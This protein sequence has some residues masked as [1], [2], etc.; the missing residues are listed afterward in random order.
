MPVCCFEVLCISPP[1]TL[2]SPALVIKQMI[3]MLVA[4]NERQFSGRLELFCL[5]AMTC[6][7]RK[8]RTIFNIFNVT[9]Y[10][11][12]NITLIWWWYFKQQ[13]V[14]QLDSLS[15]SEPFKTLFFGKNNIYFF[16]AYLTFTVQKTYCDLVLP[17]S[18][19]V[20]LLYYTFYFSCCRKLF[21]H[22]NRQRSYWLL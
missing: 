13:T 9:S 20:K 16:K 6:W 10:V 2:Q 18:K 5:C 15:N 22:F 8:V 19:K 12:Q 21:T 7:C 1:C 3:S 4:L 11:I 14:V 17:S